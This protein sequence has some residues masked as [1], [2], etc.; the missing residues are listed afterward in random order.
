MASP[1]TRPSLRD[2]AGIAGLLLGGAGMFAAMYSTQAI[3]PVLGD[4]FGVS[5]S[6]AGLTISVVVLAVAAAG[7]FWGPLSDRWGRR[8]SMI[9]ASGLLVVPTIGTALA[10]SFG[11]LLACRG[12]QGLCMP[13]LITVGVPYVAEVFAPALGGRAMGYYIGAL[14]AGGL[15]GRAG[16][17]LITEASSWRWGLGSVAALS[18][19]GTVVMRRM[20]PE[21]PPPARG[22][23]GR[24]AVSAQLHN[25]PLVVPAAIG[26]ALFFTFVGIFSYVTFRL[27]RAP[28]D[29]GT[30]ASSLIF[31]L[32]VFGVSGPVAGRLTDRFGWRRVATG[33][34]TLALLGVAVTLP[35]T[36]PTLV[37]GLTLVILGMFGGVTAA[38][39]G[40]A[41]VTEAN[42]GVATAIY[43]SAYY[44]AGALAGFVPGLAWQEWRWPGVAALAAGALVVGL[45][46]ALAGPRAQATPR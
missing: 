8:R 34:L 19:L 4:E 13:G 37:L 39:L 36:L 20:L 40:V 11:V 43:F 44:V 46:A 25:A 41:E 3:L 28:F 14:V 38:Q 12:L 6:R 21:A 30:E 22:L 9:L 33:A 32:W 35:A 1:I 23:Q 15:F 42:R 2:E 29:F 31:V 27:E 24:A 16:V 18:V 17:G 26:A 7:W 10:P 5:P 45:T